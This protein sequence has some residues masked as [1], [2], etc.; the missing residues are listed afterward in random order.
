MKRI[1]DKFNSDE[2]KQYG[3]FFKINKEY[4]SINDNSKIILVTSINPTPSGEGKTT[5]LIGIND[6]LNYFGASSIACLRQPSMGPFFGIKGGATG[7]G[8]CEI[9]G[10]NKINCGFT[11]DFFAIESANNLIYS[12]IEN[13]IYFDSELDIDKNR[14]FWKRCLDC[15]DRSLRD[16]NYK[17]SNESDEIN[18]HFTITAA[19][20]LMA[21]FCLAKSKKDFKE[22]LENTLVAL[23]NKGKPIYVK[24][25]NIIDSLILIMDDAL[26]PNLA[27]SKFENPIIIHGGPFANIAHGCNS[28][29][30]TS[31]CSNKFEY[32][33]TEAGFGA[34]L[35]AEKFINI[36]CR[37][38]NIVPSLVVVAITLKAVKHHSTI[39]NE[40]V[41]EQIKSGFE[42]VEK[43]ISNIKNFGLNFCIVINKFN[44]DNLDELNYLKKLCDSY[45]DT[46]I[47]NMWNEGPKS[48]K[49]IFDLISKNCKKNTKINFTYSLNDENEKKII[50][51][52]KKIYGA[53]NVTFSD[54]SK[55]I[56]IENKNFIKDYYICSAKT[57]FSLSQNPNLLGQPK[58]FDIHIE[59]IEINHSTKFL[60]PIISKLFLMPGLPKQPNA[61][62]IKYEY[63]K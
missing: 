10:A 43:H 5:T 45:C 48:S 12:I 21:L 63:S 27:F 23:S 57:P 59:N 55:R 3:D 51:V 36:K 42:N 60:I 2:I 62:I 16:I 4:N 15:N 37:E 20:N 14:I 52:C 46:E 35:G 32:V 19:S 7:S 24:D 22:K 54:K 40:D 58:N 41:F 47:S 17:I 33:L 34:D 8:N 38:A 18:T 56:L 13:E 25:L 44:D 53:N 39:N 49:N 6:S 29:I 28:L 1:L 50:D 26:N 9:V 31:L 11:G 30:A 61:K